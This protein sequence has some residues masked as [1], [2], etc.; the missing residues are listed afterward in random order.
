MS[1]KPS[2]TP[3]K[4]H[5]ALGDDF[6]TIT[7]ADGRIISTD[8]DFKLIV[9]AVNNHERLVKALREMLHYADWHARGRSEANDSDECKR[10]RALLSELEQE[11]KK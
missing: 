1:T 6:L 4:A 11:E 3:W 2:P 10:A 7:D 8:A 9:R 5:Q